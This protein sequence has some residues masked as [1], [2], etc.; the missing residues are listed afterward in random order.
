MTSDSPLK[1]KTILIVDDEPDILETVAE[2]LDMCI[3]DKASKY[4]TALQYLRS[5]TYDIVILDI[6]GVNGFGLLKECRKRNIP[7]AMLTARSM[8]VESLNRAIR[9]GW[10]GTGF[11]RRATDRGRRRTIPRSSRSRRCPSSVPR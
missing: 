4:S 9:D 8:D 5:Y 3:V 7:A 11:R 1:N 2:E 10:N 6:M